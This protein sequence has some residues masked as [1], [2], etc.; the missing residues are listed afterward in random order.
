MSETNYRVWAG[1][2][3]AVTQES[4]LYDT[5]LTSGHHCLLEPCL[6]GGRASGSEQCTLGTSALKFVTDTDMFNV[7]LWV[8]NLDQ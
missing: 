1:Q 4:T 6:R 2:G 8:E 3:A 7:L 5:S